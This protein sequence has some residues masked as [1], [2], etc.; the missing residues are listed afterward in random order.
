MLINNYDL[1]YLNNL[2]KVFLNNIPLNNF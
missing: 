2:I 1:I